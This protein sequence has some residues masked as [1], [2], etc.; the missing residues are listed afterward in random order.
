[1]PASEPD[2][3]PEDP[4][5]DPESGWPPFPLPPEEDPLEDPADEPLGPELLGV[6]LDPELAAPTLDPD[7]PAADELGVPPF[8]PVE[9][10]PPEDDPHAAT[11]ATRAGNTSFDRTEISLMP[12]QWRQRAKSVSTPD[13]SGHRRGSRNHGQGT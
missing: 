10:L 7:V 5:P 3:P 1:M 8:S 2:E 4:E 9:T 12:K 11:V 6:V 13:P